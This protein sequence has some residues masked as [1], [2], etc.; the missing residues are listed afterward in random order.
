MNGQVKVVKKSI[1]YSTTMFFSILLR[2]KIEESE[3]M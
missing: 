2:R 1:C 3:G